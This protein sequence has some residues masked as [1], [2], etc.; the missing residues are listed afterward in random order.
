MKLVRS[1]PHRDE[2]WRV[3]ATDI[4]R[5]WTIAAAAVLCRGM[6]VKKATSACRSWSIKLNI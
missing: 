5:R 6:R 4:G 3:Q 2:H 1:E